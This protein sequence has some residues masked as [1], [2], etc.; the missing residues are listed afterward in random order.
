MPAIC[1]P[2]RAQAMR[3]PLASPC[4]G[5]LDGKARR[6][7]PVCCA[8]SSHVRPATRGMFV[9]TSP[10]AAQ[11]PEF[12]P[13]AWTRP[14]AEQAKP[15]LLRCEPAVLLNPYYSP[16]L[17]LPRCRRTSRR[18]SRKINNNHARRREARR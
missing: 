8:T 2:C 16:H 13:G 3:M 15:F 12:D 6:R 1:C 11:V 9:A 4:Q 17:R 18:T 5:Q 14:G 7:P 10:S